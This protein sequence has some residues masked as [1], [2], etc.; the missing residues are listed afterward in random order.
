MEGGGDGAPP[1]LL[2]PGGKPPFIAVADPAE[3]GG[4]MSCPRV[5]EYDASLSMGG[6]DHSLPP[7]DTGDSG[8]FRPFMVFDAQQSG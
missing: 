6:Y 3:S 2:G 4:V 7:R 5:L 8:A 1:A